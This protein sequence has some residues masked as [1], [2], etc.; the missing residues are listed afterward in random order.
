[1]DRGKVELLVVKGNIFIIFIFIS[2]EFCFLLFIADE[3]SRLPGDLELDLKAILSRSKSIRNMEEGVSSSFLQEE[4]DAFDQIYSELLGIASSDRDTEEKKKMA[5]ELKRRSRI[6]ASQSLDSAQQQQQQ[7][8]RSCHFKSSHLHSKS[9]D[10]DSCRSS[11]NEK[12]GGE[13]GTKDVSSCPECRANRQQSPGLSNKNG[14]QSPFSPG[15]SVVADLEADIEDLSF[16][17][18]EQQYDTGDKLFLDLLDDLDNI[19]GNTPSARRRKRARDLFSDWLFNQ[20]S[21]D[22]ESPQKN[23]DSFSEYIEQFDADFFSAI[24][25]RPLRHRKLHTRWRPKSRLFDYHSEVS[26]ICIYILLFY[27]C[28]LSVHLPPQVS[29]A[30]V[31]GLY[32]SP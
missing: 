1:M 26:V 4:L 32:K 8:R 6:L 7:H 24:N 5:A 19:S 17:A 14:R 11:P 20:E 29:P 2:L 10:Q 16:I 3:Y 18:T 25:P 27:P 28:R 15:S 13:N 30:G 31:T 23:K 12:G 9:C 21:I 22:E